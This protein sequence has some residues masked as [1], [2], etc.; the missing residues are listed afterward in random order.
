MHQLESTFLE[1]KQ[2]FDEPDELGLAAELL[3]V[4]NEEELE[5]FIGGLIKGASKLVRSPR[6]RRWAA[7]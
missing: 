4:T 1:V 2:A 7:S 3:S 6:A 5:N